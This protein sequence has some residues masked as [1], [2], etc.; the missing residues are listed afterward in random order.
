MRPTTSADPLDVL[1]ELTGDDIR[2]RLASIDAERE[3][4]RVLLRSV[5][6]RERHEARARQLRETAPALDRR[7]TVDAR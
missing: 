2:R 4:L 1:R 7:G 5:S 3:Q 6:A